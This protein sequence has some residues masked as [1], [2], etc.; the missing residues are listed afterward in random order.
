MLQ[1]IKYFIGLNST[2]GEVLKKVEFIFYSN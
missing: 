1:K 2:V